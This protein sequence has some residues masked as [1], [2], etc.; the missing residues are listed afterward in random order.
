VVEG[1][2]SI[3][4]ADVLMPIETLSAYVYQSLRKQIVGDNTEDS[5][6]TGENRRRRSF[7]TRRVRRKARRRI[8]DAHG[9]W[10]FYTLNFKKPEK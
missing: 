10:Y 5:G 6:V 3:D 8:N 4:R 7:L 1:V 9:N 2:G